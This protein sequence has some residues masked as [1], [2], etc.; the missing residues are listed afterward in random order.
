MIGR[1]FGI[2]IHKIHQCIFEKRLIEVLAAQNLARRKSVN[3]IIKC[4]VCQKSG[5]DI[6]TCRKGIHLHHHRNLIQGLLCP[7]GFFDAS[8]N[9]CIQQLI[10]IRK[11]PLILIFCKKV[12]VVK[13]QNIRMFVV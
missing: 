8:E 3:D 11:N 2:K 6:G 1:C 9:R 4:F 13:N 10:E 5:Y 12:R 7:K